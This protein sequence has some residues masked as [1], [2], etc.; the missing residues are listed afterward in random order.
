MVQEESWVGATLC[1]AV[2][3][4]ACAINL[5]AGEEQGELVNELVGYYTTAEFPTDKS[6]DLAEN[7]EFL[8]KEYIDDRIVQ[9]VS[10]SALC[11][12]SVTKWCVESGYGSGH[13]RRSERC[14]RVAGDTAAKAVEIL[15]SWKDGTF[16]PKF[17]LSSETQG[18][19]G[20]HS[21]GENFEEGQFTR[22]NMQCT[23]CHE[24]HSIPPESDRIR[25][26]T[27]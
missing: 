2:N 16:E 27:K 7:N 6:N 4:S 25:S 15:N 8:A 20:C 14:A 13:P 21:K 19:K 5:A 1:G 18:C 11:H 10:G 12:V 3:G 26:R 22:G 23:N 17:E 24:S 9:S